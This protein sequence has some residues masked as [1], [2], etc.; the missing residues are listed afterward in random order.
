MRNEQVKLCSI[1]L[2]GNSMEYGGG[3]HGSWY[4]HEPSEIAKHYREQLT[5][6]VLCIDKRPALEANYS[7]AFASPMVNV[8]MEEGEVDQFVSRYL[9]DGGSALMVDA[10]KEHSPFGTIIKAAETV[11]EIAPKIAGPLDFVPIGEYVKWWEDRGAI[12]YRYDG[13]HFQPV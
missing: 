3:C 7:F 8:D 12:I 10:L 2:G 5:E 11:A 6:G 4:L 1:G 13:E 9:Q